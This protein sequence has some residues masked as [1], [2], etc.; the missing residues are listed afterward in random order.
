MNPSARKLPPCRKRRLLRLIAAGVV[1]LPYVRSMDLVYHIFQQLCVCTSLVSKK[2]TMAD[3]VQ[4]VT[5]CCGYSEHCADTL[6]S[7][8]VWTHSDH[9]FTPSQ[10]TTILNSFVAHVSSISTVGLH[11][12]IQEQTTFKTNAGSCYVLTSI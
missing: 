11:R 2:S 9:P 3:G 6:Y 7:Y 4:Q 10:F 5:V 12:R 8:S 1:L